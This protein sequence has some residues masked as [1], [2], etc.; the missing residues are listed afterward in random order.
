MNTENG[1]EQCYI[2]TITD[3]KMN[4]KNGSNLSL[5]GPNEAAAAKTC[6]EPHFTTLSLSYDMWEAFLSISGS[7]YLDRANTDIAFQG[8]LIEAYEAYVTTKHTPL[9]R[10]L[11]NN[12]DTMAISQSPSTQGSISASQTTNS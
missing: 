8:M 9:S 5:F 7:T 3:I 12:I 10:S 11:E 1:M 6:L 4:L 2:A